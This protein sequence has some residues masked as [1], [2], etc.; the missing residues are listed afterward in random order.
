ME[1]NTFASCHLESTFWIRLL[2]VY[3][4]FNCTY[5][6]MHG[7]KLIHLS[8]HLSK[9]FIQ[10]R[11]FHILRHTVCTQSALLDSAE[12]HLHKRLMIG[13]KK[14]APSILN[15]NTFN[16]I[17]GIKSVNIS[18]AELRYYWDMLATAWANA[19]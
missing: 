7:R 14:M 17:T 9:Y 16:I 5:C 6:I 4:L 10:I 11:C 2:V 15:S 3:Q 1:R 8:K 18:S 12:V 13:S 19:K